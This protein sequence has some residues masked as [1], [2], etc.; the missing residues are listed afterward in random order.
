MAGKINPKWLEGL[1][2]RMKRIEKKKDRETGQAVEIFQTRP[3][4]A[5]DVLS[6]REDGDVVVIIV[7]D[8]RKHRVAKVVGK[9]PDQK[10]KKE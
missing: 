5:G 6:V 9:A 1:E 4:T 3:V 2:F 8:G 10:D 7:A